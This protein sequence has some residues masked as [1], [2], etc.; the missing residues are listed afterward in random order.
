MRNELFFLTVHK[1]HKRMTSQCKVKR[2]SVVQ[3]HGW[4]NDTRLSLLYPV[5][6]FVTRRERSAFLGHVRQNRQN[7]KYH[8]IWNVALGSDLRGAKLDERGDWGVGPGA[9]G[10]QDDGGKSGG[11]N[12][13]I[14]NPGTRGHLFVHLP[15]T[16]RWDV[17][18]TETYCFRLITKRKIW[19]KERRS[20]YELILIKSTEQRRSH[21]LLLYQ[22]VMK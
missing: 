22:I 10:R 5:L 14:W 12:Q 1:S 9:G 19:H 11:G 6:C 4:Q 3:V 15:H 2:G 18:M 17:F 7:I 20:A 8:Q 16:N 21:R 13:A